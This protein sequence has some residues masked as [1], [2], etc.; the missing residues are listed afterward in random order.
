MAFQYETVNSGGMSTHYHARSLIKKGY[1]DH[2]HVWEILQETDYGEMDYNSYG[3]GVEHFVV[4]LYRC[5]LCGALHK[6]CR[7]DFCG[8]PREYLEITD[9]DIA[10]AERSNRKGVYDLWET[11]CCDR[12]MSGGMV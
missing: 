9:T 1:L 2:E 6:E 10:I 5:R 4:T 7:G 3:G 8:D 11:A 12:S